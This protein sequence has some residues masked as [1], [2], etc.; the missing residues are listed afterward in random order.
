MLFPG[1]YIKTFSPLLGLLSL[2]LQFSFLF[3]LFFSFL[4]LFFFFCMKAVVTL[5]L[6]G[7]A[8]YEVDIASYRWW[9][10]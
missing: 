6:S 10:E 4:L 8:L 7:L 9:P 5:L 1:I 3:F 2:F